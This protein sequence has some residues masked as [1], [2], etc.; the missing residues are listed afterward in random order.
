M[1]ASETA[2]E[3]S[4]AHMSVPLIMAESRRVGLVAATMPILV[5]IVIAGIGWSLVGVWQPARIAVAMNW[6]S[7][8]FVITV[9]ICA[10]TALTGDRLVEVH[11]STPTPFRS[12][13]FRRV[14]VVT[15][16]AVLGAVAAFA[17]SHSLGIWPNDEGWVSVV[18]PVGAAVFIIAIAL[19]FAAYSGNAAT[20]SIGVVVGWMFLS[21][22]WD[23]YVLVLAA[24]RGL[25]LLASVAM[26]ATAWQRLGD[27][28]ALIGKEVPA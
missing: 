13:Q 10:A 9:G 16:S 7:Q 11:E 22:L 17:A 8:L 12:T 6:L 1:T 24:Q 3:R 5:G 19:L 21:L 4:V 14:G 20:T 26:V 2:A 18:S 28:E 23:P 25:L 15:V 27:S